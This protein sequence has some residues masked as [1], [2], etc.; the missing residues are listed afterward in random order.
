MLY[1]PVQCR[2]FL[3]TVLLKI[4][5]QFLQRCLSSCMFCERFRNCALSLIEKEVPFTFWFR[6]VL[7]V[8]VASE[9]LPLMSLT[10]DCG[11]HLGRNGCW[12]QTSTRTQFT[13]CIDFFSWLS[14]NTIKPLNRSKVLV[15][16]KSLVDFWACSWPG[17]TKLGYTH[18][19]TYKIQRP[20]QGKNFPSINRTEN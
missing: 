10:Y 5:W 8:F 9:W 13:F 3:C 14:L 1:S 7:G 18:T 6:S 2:S 12:P 17:A 4:H 20:V 19:P 11:L 16:V 15:Y